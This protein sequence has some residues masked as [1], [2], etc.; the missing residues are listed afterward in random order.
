MFHA[1]NLLL[2]IFIH[3]L[4]ELAEFFHSCDVCN[5]FNAIGNLVYYS[6]CSYFITSVHMLIPLPIKILNCFL[7]EQ[8]RKSITSPSPLASL[9]CNSFQRY[10]IYNHFQS[11][12]LPPGPTL[13]VR[14]NKRGRRASV[15]AYK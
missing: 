2:L 7:K 13:P 9:C 4:V 11:P 14:R 5:S 6:V 3:F 1:K 8:V 12:I 15:S 10:F